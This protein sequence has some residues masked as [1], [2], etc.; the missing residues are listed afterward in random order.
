MNNQK[1]ASELVKV[2]KSLVAD[3]I[4]E[5]V[6][7]NKDVLKEIKKL[8]KDLGAT[9]IRGNYRGTGSKRADRQVFVRFGEGGYSSDVIDI[10]VK[11]GGTTLTAN[12]SRLGVPP[13]SHEGKTPAQVYKIILKYLTAWRKNNES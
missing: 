3:E 5:A 7:F 12:G 4:D 6:E 2:A 9:K 11:K 10:W 8:K 13:I 1:I